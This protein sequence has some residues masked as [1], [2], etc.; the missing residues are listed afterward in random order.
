MRGK[1][2]EIELKK[3]IAKI[4][5]T[6]SCFSE[7][8]NKIDKTLARLIKKKRNR[9]QINKIRNKREEA[10]ADTPEIQR[11]IRDHSGS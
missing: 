11:A 4:H 2:S 1:I 5:E 3:T 6:K 8:V 7:K 9:V 10:T